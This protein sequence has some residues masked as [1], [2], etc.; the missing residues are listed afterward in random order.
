S[1]V[2][3]MDLVNYLSS[4]GHE[5][6]KQRNHDFWY[7][8]PLREENTPSFKVN[9]MLN[10][11]YDHGIGKGG[12]TIDF[13]IQYHQC[14]VAELLQLLSNGSPLP[15]PFYTNVDVNLE[16]ETKIVVIENYALHSHALLKYLNQRQIPL[17]IANEFC[18][19]V[20]YTIHDKT[21][22]GIGFKNDSGA[23]EIRNPY[24]KSGSS[25]KDISTFKTGADEVLVFEGFMD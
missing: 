18:R 23:W 15:R 20:R 22:F 13:A 4:L 10:K 16:A 14:T 7:H 1:E 8:S 2:K 12:N 19:E 9:R 24:F 17:V 21:Y 25:P 3:E 5:P 11:W 6:T